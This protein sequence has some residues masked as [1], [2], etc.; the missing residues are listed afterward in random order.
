MAD[1]SH[2]GEPVSRRRIIWRYVVPFLYIVFLLL[3]LLLAAQYE[4]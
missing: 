4:L 3:P 2:V 1:H